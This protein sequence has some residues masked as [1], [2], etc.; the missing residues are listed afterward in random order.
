MTHGPPVKPLPNGCLQWTGR[1]DSGATKLY[2]WISVEGKK[3]RPH[4]LV[5][6]QH[7]GL[8][9]LTDNMQFRLQHLCDTELCVNASHW[10][11]P[12][13]ATGAMK[14]PAKTRRR[15]ED[16][17]LREALPGAPGEI[18]VE[19]P[20]IVATKAGVERIAG[21]CGVRPMIVL[22]IYGHM[23]RERDG[24]LERFRQSVR[25][26][27]EPMTLEDILSAQAQQAQGEA[28]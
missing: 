7:Y 2:P 1:A 28:P 14:I 11:P 18:I 17:I 4:R 21:W 6:A 3:Y 22:A 16:Y 23:V 9:H 5:W 12:M 10:A 8:S 27:Y 26:R 19:K 13:R 15:I 20:R 24:G 25:R